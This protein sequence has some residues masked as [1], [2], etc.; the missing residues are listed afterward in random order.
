M[1]IPNLLI[2]IFI[3]SFSYDYPL[4]SL[5]STWATI[6]ASD[7]TGC[8]LVLVWLLSFIFKAYNIKKPLT[9]QLRWYLIICSITSI[10]T[11]IFMGNNRDDL[12]A[13]EYTGYWLLK[14][15]SY[16]LF[17][18]II[19]EFAIDRASAYKFLVIFWIGGIF[20]SIY[21]ILQYY[22]ILPQFWDD[23]VRTPYAITST[24]SFHHGHLGLYMLVIIFLTVGLLFSSPSKLWKILF[25]FS[26]LPFIYTEILSLRRTTWIG[27]GV[28]LICWIMFNSERF[29]HKIKR[30]IIA[31]VVG[32]AI[33]VAFYYSETAQDRSEPIK[34]FF[35]YFLSEE[36]AL[37]QGNKQIDVRLTVMGF[38]I[39]ILREDPLSLIYGQGFMSSPMRYEYTGAHNEFIQI[40]HD[41]GI[42]GLIIY[43]WLMYSILKILWRNSRKNNDNWNPVYNA[44]FC[45]MIGLLISGIPGGFF[46]T[47]HV[48]GSFLGFFLSLLGVILGSTFK[49]DLQ[50]K[51]AMGIGKESDNANRAFPVLKNL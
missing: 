28:G 49:S 31:L 5:Y 37:N 1:K 20:I 2:Y 45:C 40:L 16:I 30:Y 24:L 44:F 39:D 13:F 34:Y 32:I 35:K 29:S 41:S 43:L 51:L 23:L 48:Y 21:G 17:Y 8:F 47:S 6:K 33:A 36:N 3:L 19:F 9:N 11:I 10:P 15:F 14:L 38:F 42:I 18:F 25:G 4:I 7:I 26:L 12:I 50:V 46:T 27:I 22:G